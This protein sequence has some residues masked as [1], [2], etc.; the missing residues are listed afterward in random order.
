M[1]AKLKS[2]RAKML[3]GTVPVVVIMFAI[4]SVVV[5]LTSKSLI[6]KTVQ[7]KIDVQMAHAK[8]QITTHLVAHE[9]LPITLAEAVKAGGINEAS[10]KSL[11]EMVKNMPSTNQDTLGTG[12]FMAKK[13]EGSYFC[14]YAYK[15][16]GKI[17]YTEDY[18]VDNTNEGWYVIAKDAERVAWSNPYYDPVSGI[19][20]V[21]ASSPVRDAGGNL[22]GVT[23]GDLDFTEIQKIMG[24]LKV[25]KTGY[26]ML[27]SSDGDYLSKKDEKIEID[28]S[29]I[30]P[31]ITEDANQSLAKLG[32]MVVSQKS[33][34]GRFSDSDGTNL[35]YFSPID[36]T[37]W[38]VMLVLPQ[39]EVIEPVNQIISKV[40]VLTVLALL[41][42]VALIMAVSKS[43]TKP[44]KPL[45]E[46]IE[47]IAKGDLTRAV[48]LDSNDEV[49]HIAQSINNMVSSLKE[50]VKNISDS[51][52][53]V[54]S[55]AEEL[56]ASAGQNGIVVEQV[57]V[58]A[59]EISSSNL[60][61]AKLTTNLEN[62]V[63]SVNEVSV[64]IASQM[65]SI[66]AVAGEMGGISSTSSDSVKSLIESMRQ[67]FD[68]VKNLTDIMQRLQSQ[69]KQIYTIVETIQGISGQT[70]LLAL[71]A[72]IEA[73][74]AGEAGRGFAVVAEE[75]RKLAEQTSESANDIS[76]IITDVVGISNDANQTTETVVESIDTSKEALE[77]VNQAF[78]DIIQEIANIS[79]LIEN[80]SVLTEEIEQ[81][82]RT[83]TESALALAKQTDKSAEQATSI[84][85][86][87]EEQLAS[88]EEQNSATMG[89][90]QMAE[91]LE[92]K[93]SYFK[94]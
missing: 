60:E 11:T 44:L 35:V 63:R 23:T 54:A 6:E 33:G 4:L 40:I 58:S 8:N 22:I 31:K 91:T 53:N 39:S 83:A 74:R 94:L 41:I 55:T 3:V 88:V 29:G 21:T 89:L 85:A 26:A 28:E 19:T 81:K 30:F 57:A 34:E 77:T 92:S 37:G 47:L 50:I 90:A 32:Q 64:G 70:N 86:S 36:E 72:S 38:I 56:E 46:E 76:G 69:S 10:K 84:A 20:M 13:Y 17:L 49:G 16:D 43:I 24:E 71:N 14:P 80:A 45:K 9:M 5:T 15:S 1:F 75:I 52:E 59:T 65:D 48:K 66:N 78:G 68:D 27:L 79:K 67:A 62:I 12:I 2:I 73:A 93:V 42:L 51:A 7:E 18:F 87:T 25:G 82:S 61:I